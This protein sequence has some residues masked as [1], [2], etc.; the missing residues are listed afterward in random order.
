MNKHYYDRYEI[1]VSA[2]PQDGL[3]YP[4]DHFRYAKIY[5][6]DKTVSLNASKHGIKVSVNGKVISSCLVTS[7]GGATGID[8]ASSL[9]NKDRLFVCCG[10]CVFC[11]SVPDLELKWEIKADDAACFQIFKIRNDYLVHGE[12][13]ISMLTSD[14]RIKWQFSGQDIFVVTGR[15]GKALIIEDDRIVLTDFNGRRYVLD[16]DGKET[17]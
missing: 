3:K 10:Y 7:S 4:L 6:A 14:G 16:Y 13:Q 9:I 8:T 1:T 5:S 15:A 17:V 11:L 2:E 12:T